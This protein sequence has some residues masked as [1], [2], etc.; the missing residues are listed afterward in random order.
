MPD[1]EFEQ[2]LQLVVD[3]WGANALETAIARV[4]WSVPRRRLDA[5]LRGF[6]PAGRRDHAVQIDESILREAMKNELRRLVRH[7]RRART[8]TRE[9]D[10]QHVNQHSRQFAEELDQLKH[11][12]ITMAGLADE[13]L[14]LALSGLVDAD[15][16]LLADVVG[17][18]SRINALQ[19]EI[20]DRCLKLIARRHPVAV[21]LR[22][23]VSALK[24]NVDLERVGDLAVNIGEAAQRYLLH[25]PVKP[26][27]DIPRMGDVAL[28]M[29]RA[30][31][32]AFVGRDVVPAKSVLRQ[33]DWLDALKDQIFRELLTYMLGDRATIEPAIELILIARHLERIGDHAT[34]IAEDVISIVEARDVRHRSVPQPFERRRDPHVASV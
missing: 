4:L 28:R 14:R 21:D 10:N 31:I 20:D 6:V 2:L 17:G 27:I 3:L 24:I 13:R 12:L 15:P 33:D 16:A 26:L 22:A 29:L 9:M 32:E 11:R 23:V 8:R 5:T 34:N 18:D 19:I 1:A 7:S 30:A 25:P